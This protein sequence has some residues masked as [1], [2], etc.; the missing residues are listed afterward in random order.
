MRRVHKH[1][2][3]IILLVEDQASPNIIGMNENLVISIG[4]LLSAR[5]SDL[6]IIFFWDDIFGYFDC[7]QFFY[8]VISC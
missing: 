5:N 3:N 2:W 6:I 7:Q 1:T 8:D 4:K